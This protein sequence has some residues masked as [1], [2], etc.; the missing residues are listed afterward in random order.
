MDLLE[1]D[2]TKYLEVFDPEKYDDIGSGIRYFI[3]LISGITNNFSYYYTK[4]Y[5]V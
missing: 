5:F 4:T 1:F 2:K 3:S